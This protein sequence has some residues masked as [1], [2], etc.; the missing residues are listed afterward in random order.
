MRLQQHRVAI[1]AVCLPM[2][3]AV[4]ACN[5]PPAAPP[6]APA[7]AATAASASS[8]PS[9]DRGKMLV[10]GGGCHDCHT[11]M[12]PGANGAEPDMTK[13]LSGHPESISITAAMKPVGPWTV[14]TNATNTAWSG[15]WGV[16]FAA[17]LTPDKETGLNM[18]ERNFVIALKTGAH[19]GT[20]R[21]ILPPMPWPWYGQLGDDA[22]KDIYA[23]LLTIPPLKNQ[24][25]APIPPDGK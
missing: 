21:P 4:T 24:V 3:I 23:Y 19:L 10:I 18:T 1:L 13:M 14:A 6:A 8:T 20:A 17:N 22:L 12:K 2:A 25:P 9:V 5:Q 7:P 11:P 16:S 15:P